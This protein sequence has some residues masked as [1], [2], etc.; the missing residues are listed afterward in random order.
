MRLQSLRIKE[1]ENFEE[2]VAVTNSGAKSTTPSYKSRRPL[3]SQNL[4]REGF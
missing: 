1:N 4:R 3:Q 2:A